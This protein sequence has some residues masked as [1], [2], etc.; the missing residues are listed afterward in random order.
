MT[1]L[2]TYRS[3]KTEA[4]SCA[5]Q[6]SV[7]G[8]QAPISLVRGFSSSNCVTSR[9]WS[10]LISDLH[11]ANDCT[12]QQMVSGNHAYTPSG[13]QAVLAANSTITGN[14]GH[15]MCVCAEAGYEKATRQ[16]ER[17]QKAAQTCM[18]LMLVA[19]YMCKEC[20]K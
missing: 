20:M 12:Q 14:P 4:V 7:T 8:E 16:A 1:L 11:G 19:G 6:R 13:Y 15:C 9:V 3:W 2:L 18:H 5:R 17:R 10:V